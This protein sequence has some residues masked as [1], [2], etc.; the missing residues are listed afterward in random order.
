MRPR[1]PCSLLS[2]LETVVGG[3]LSPS[4]GEVHP[5]PG[6][7][8]VRGKNDGLSPPALLFSPGSPPPHTHTHLSGRRYKNYPWGWAASCPSPDSP[9]SLP[10]IREGRCLRGLLVRRE[11]PAP[12][13][14]V[15]VSLRGEE[16]GAMSRKCLSPLRMLSLLSVLGT[17]IP[18]FCTH[19]HCGWEERG[20]KRRE[21]TLRSVQPLP[22][23]RQGPLCLRWSWQRPVCSQDK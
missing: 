11:T 4:P 10:C 1:P 22:K 16:L 8:P 15:S 20:R 5:C 6:P 12:G 13:L 23:A 2:S 17:G 19:C 21:K 18:L 3:C 7:M 9:N 14:K